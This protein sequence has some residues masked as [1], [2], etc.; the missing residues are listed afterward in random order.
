V[1]VHPRNLVLAAAGAL[2]GLGLLLAVLRPAERSDQQVLSDLVSDVATAVGNRDVASILEHVSD[3]FSG[4][5]GE[6]RSR[7]EVRR[8]LLAVL[9]RAGWTQVVVLERTFDVQGD[10]ADGTVRFVGLR[11]GSA[12]VSL[13]SLRPG[14][15]A[16]EVQARFRR[17]GD[18]WR[19]VGASYRNIGPQGIR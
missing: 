3:G 14:M 11:G 15:Q 10:G 16:Y 2:L 8:L 9:M 6:I 19:V 18:A 13:A 7:D 17:E 5:S 12:P 1:T 4:G